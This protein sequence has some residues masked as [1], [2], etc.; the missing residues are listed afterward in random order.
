MKK[1]F[2]ID[3]KKIKSES[4]FNNWIL[5]HNERKYK[6]QRENVDQTKTKDNITMTECKYKSYKNFIQAKKEEI[7]SLNKENRKKRKQL[8]EELIKQGYDKK[9]A[10]KIARQKYPKRR[11]PSM[12]QAVGF[13]IVVD[14][15]VMEGWSNDDYIAYLKDAEAFL[16][17]RFSNLEILS[18]V[19]HLDES[20]PHLHISFS[21]WDENEKRFKEKELY[22]KGLTN[23]DKLLDDFKHSVGQKYNLDRGDGATI[24]KSLIRDLNKQKKAVE[25][26]TDTKLFGLIKQTKQVAVLPPKTTKQILEQKFKQ[27][28]ELGHAEKVKELLV[29]NRKLKENQE[30]LKEQIKELQ[31]EKKELQMKIKTISKEKEK[32]KSKNLILTKQNEKLKEAIT[33]LINE[34]AETKARISKN[35]TKAKKIVKEKIKEKYKDLIR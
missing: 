17:S 19:I 20:K 14:C 27:V 7:Q 34:L 29:E 26:V 6:L 24:K 25:I 22:E 35:F 8:V 9:E 18:S 30:K 1:Y 23:L 21:Y 12:D 28:K 10:Q 5:G 2:V 15:S 13:S 31:Q 3:F 33:K 4:Q 32:L 16:K 11:S